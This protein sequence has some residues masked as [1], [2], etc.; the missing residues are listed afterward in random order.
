LKT[1][2]IGLLLGVCVTLSMGQR[3]AEPAHKLDADYRYQISA[4]PEQ[5][6]AYTLFIL[7]HETNKV[8]SRQGF[9]PNGAGR[10]IKQLI[11]EIGR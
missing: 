5:N 3:A 7:D 11:G 9:P 2:L 4:V 6:G 8:Y 10:E 1:L